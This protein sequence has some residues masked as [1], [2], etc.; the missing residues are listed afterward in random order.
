MAVIRTHVLPSG[1][2][3]LGERA[4]ELGFTRGA[5]I[6]VIPTSAGSLLVVLD[7]SPPTY[8]ATWKALV[9]GAAQLAARAARRTAGN[10][11][12]NST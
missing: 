1:L 12:G 7:H 4:R 6:E 10:S 5:V 2:V 8:D 9:G 11:D 3:D